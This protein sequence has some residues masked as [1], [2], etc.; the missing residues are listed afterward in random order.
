[1]HL[2]RDRGAEMEQGWAAH[3]CESLQI[4]SV[5][6]SAGLLVVWSALA[7]TGSADVAPDRA[8]DGLSACPGHVCYARVFGHSDHPVEGLAMEGATSERAGLLHRLLHY[9]ACGFELIVLRRARG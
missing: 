9:N 2:C 4:P 3:K 6:L 1:M 8:G 7:V 5:P